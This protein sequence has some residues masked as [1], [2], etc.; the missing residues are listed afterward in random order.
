MEFYINLFKLFVEFQKQSS[1]EIGNKVTVK[2]F[3]DLNRKIKQ[4]CILCRT[5]KN[6]HP[7]TTL[8]HLHILFFNVH[9]INEKM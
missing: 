8:L 3:L 4:V 9:L 5:L 1:D 7:T 2:S 6:S